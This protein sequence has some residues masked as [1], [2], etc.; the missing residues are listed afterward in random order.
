MSRNKQSALDVIREYYLSE[1]GDVQLT[2]AQLQK[3]ERLSA[4][5]SLL[6]EY[7][8]FQ[9]AIPVLQKRFGLSRSQAY[10]DVKDAVTLFGNVLKSDKEGLRYIIYE[11]ALKTFQFAAEMK[12]FKSMNMA[13]SNM[14]KLLGLDKEDPDLPDFTR[15]QPNV[16]PILLDDQSKELADNLLNQPGPLNLSKL[17]N[18]HAT[19]TEYTD[20]SERTD[21][22]GDQEAT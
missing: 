5:Y 1:E 4:A 17:M 16:Y 6:C 13:V 11:Y 8:S 2:E 20:L 21:Q 12:D 22:K 18:K 3:K 9:Q 7:H 10:R 19:D 15:L 14:I